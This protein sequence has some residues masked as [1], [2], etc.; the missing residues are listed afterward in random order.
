MNIHT[1]KDVVTS[2]RSALI[3]DVEDDDDDDDEGEEVQQPRERKGLEEEDDDDDLI[4]LS[5]RRKDAEVD[6]EEEDGNE[7]FNEMGTVIEPF[8][9]KD[10]REGGHF[11]ENQNYVFKKE[12]GEVDAWVAEM[13]EVAMERA[14]GEAQ[15]AMKIKIAKREQEDIEEDMKTKRSP[16]ELKK[17][18]LPYL[19]IGETPVTAM[20]R[21]SGKDA[22]KGTRSNKNRRV[23]GSLEGTNGSKVAPILT[24][25]ERKRNRQAIESITEIADRLVASGLNGIYQMS[26]E[27]LEASTVMWEYQGVGADGVS[28]MVYGP[29]SSEQIAGWKASGYF[30]GSTSVMM[31]RVI[32]R[33]FPKASHLAGSATESKSSMSIYDDDEVPADTASSVRSSAAATDKDALGGRWMEWVS[34]D[35]VDFGLFVQDGAIE[36]VGGKRKGREEGAASIHPFGG[37]DADDD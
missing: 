22:S 16:L 2:R 20:R 33:Q 4:A 23:K 14:I 13:D 11:D 24:V 19:R 29:F 34:S 30:T 6:G 10:E 7:K 36:G 9:L 27:A 31:R 37:D 8:N 26:Q 25:E 15:M 21:F 28:S 12:R 3:N 32:D 1:F 17:Q 18:L 5:R 35:D